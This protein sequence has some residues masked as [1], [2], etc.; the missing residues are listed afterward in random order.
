M[1]ELMLSNAASS[2]SGEVSVG[3]AEEVLEEERG[4][5]AAGVEEVEVD[6]S[7]ADG[8]GGDTAVA[9][10]GVEV[11]VGVLRVDVLEVDTAESLFG[12]CSTWKRALRRS[13]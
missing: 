3:V 4:E 13:A 12:G 8:L 7:G 5:A 6:I 9:A 1:A 10:A 2:E 11:E